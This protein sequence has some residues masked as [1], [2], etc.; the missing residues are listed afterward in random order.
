MSVQK[1]KKK[2]DGEKGGLTY[3]DASA[4]YSNS[5]YTDSSGEIDNIPLFVVEGIEENDL[6]D[7]AKDNTSSSKTESGSK[8]RMI[9]DFATWQMVI[10]LDVVGVNA[11]WIIYSPSQATASK[12]KA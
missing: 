10:R 3:E 11:K 4:S 1:K 9:E 5:S 7:R 8:F 6:G 12:I 2:K